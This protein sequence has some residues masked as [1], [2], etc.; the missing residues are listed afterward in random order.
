MAW[1]PLICCVTNGIER[2]KDGL[3]VE[4]GVNVPIKGSQALE[5]PMPYLLRLSTLR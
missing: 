4:I 2:E 1:R 3:H 5:F